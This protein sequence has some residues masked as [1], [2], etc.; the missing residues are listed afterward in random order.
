MFEYHPLDL[1]KNEIRLIS[2][3]PGRPS[4]NLEG[5]I[6]HVSLDEEPKY[7]ALSYAWHDSRH[8]N[9]SKY[10]VS[11]FANL[12]IMRLQYLITRTPLAAPCCGQM[13][14]NGKLFQLGPNLEAAVRRLR[15]CDENLVM[16]ID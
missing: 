4:D 7:D 12:L 8:I 6:F 10:A 5:H 13:R 15:T 11:F 1:E 3:S 14:I 9:T 2:I 16:W